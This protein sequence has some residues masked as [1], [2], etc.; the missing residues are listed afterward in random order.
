MDKVKDLA[1]PLKPYAEKVPQLVDVAGKIGQPVEVLLLALVAVSGIVI[2]VLFGGT[3]F[4]LV[5]TVIYPAIQ[6]IKAIESDGGDDDKEWLTYWTI[7]GLATLL[8]EFAGFLLTFIPFYFYLRPIFFV[9]L[10]APQTKGALFLYNNFV[11]PLLRN[12]KA[13]IQN[14]ID[15]IKGSAAD[16]QKAAKDEALKQVNDPSNL[17]KATQMAAQAQQQLN[18]LDV[19]Q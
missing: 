1:R 13:A 15:E 8:D 14:F 17:M 12:N 3:I 16:L 4:T 5:L 2:L 18:K 6:S 11:G 10:M 9:F 7:F 19:Q